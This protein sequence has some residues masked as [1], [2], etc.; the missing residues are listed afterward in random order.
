MELITAVQ[1]IITIRRFVESD[2]LSHLASIQLD[3][4]A[5]A[6]ANA[7]IANDKR[8]SYWS[9]IN[10]LEDAE[11]IYKKKINSAKCDEACRYYCYV[12]A[13][14]AVIFRYLGE[15]LLV[16]KCCEDSQN[17]E[18]LRRKYKEADML[19]SFNIPSLF[20]LVSMVL[21]K[22]E[23]EIKARRFNPSLFW[24]TMLN[25]NTDFSL[26]VYKNEKL[27]SDNVNI[28]WDSY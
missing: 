7:E 1:S 23:L 11:A 27:D 17:I 9:C 14:K 21:S 26:P 4:A 8:N 28:D 20:S 25:K 18:N 15:E 24:L 10:H 5:E 12:S 16:E 2:L 13:L 22:G 3:A 6:L 19:G